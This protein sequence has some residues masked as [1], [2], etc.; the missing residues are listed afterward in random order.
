MI[1]LNYRIIRGEMCNITC[2][3]G[4]INMKRM[5]SI[6]EGEPPKING[7]GPGNI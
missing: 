1:M 2:V 3:I 6:L 7:F 5:E 4:G